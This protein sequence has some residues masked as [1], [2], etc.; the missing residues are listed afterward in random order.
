MAEMVGR[1]DIR[2]AGRQVLVAGGGSQSPLWTG[3]IEQ[4]L[5]VKTSC[6]PSLVPSLER[7]AHG[8][9]LFKAMKTIL[10]QPSWRIATKDVEAYVTQL[11]GH[12][13]PVT[14]DRTG[15]KILACI[16]SRRGLKKKFR[17]NLLMPLIQRVARAISFVS[18]LVGIRNRI[19][20]KIIRRMAKQPTRNGNWNRRQTAIC[21]LA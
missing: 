4:K 16:R 2:L 12:L 13:A 11:G 14:F 5:G 9:A 6:P 7:C 8:S 19:A 21:I 20:G 18:R 10:G 15:K 3:L 1:L 17:L